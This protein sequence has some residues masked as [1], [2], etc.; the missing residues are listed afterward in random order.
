MIPGKK[1]SPRTRTSRRPTPETFAH[2]R[3]WITPVVQDIALTSIQEITNINQ[4]LELSSKLFVSNII[5]RV[6]AQIIGKYGDGFVTIEGTEDGRLKVELDGYEAD[7]LSTYLNAA[8]ELPVITSREQKV[9]TTA[10]ISINATGPTTIVTGQALK[11][12]KIS[13]LVWTVGGDTDITLY[14]GATDI[15]GAMAF[16]GDDEPR[17]MVSQQGYLPIE[18][19]VG[20]DFKI[21][22]S[23]AVQIS[24]F[25]SGY[26]E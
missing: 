9:V 17:G 26:I 22:C 15:S 19:G 23:A 21:G 8:G 2:L 18:L 14:S 25:V 6:I 1:Y 24:G 12:I 13:T 10:K 20:E 4:Q 5:S 11:K 3:K 16:G 7:L